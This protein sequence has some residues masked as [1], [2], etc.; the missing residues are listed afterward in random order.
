MMKF[1]YTKENNH[2][3]GLSNDESSEWTDILKTRT[4]DFQLIV[5]SRIQVRWLIKENLTIVK[6][7]I[8]IISYRGIN[9]YE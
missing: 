3:L 6:R 9:I 5:P 2:Y 8:I 4:L 1:Y 7:L